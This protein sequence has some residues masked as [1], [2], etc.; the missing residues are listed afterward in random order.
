MR[1]T[2]HIKLAWSK[3]FG[4][5]EVLRALALG[6]QRRGLGRKFAADHAYE[7]EI[8]QDYADIGPE[9]DE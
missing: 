5:P 6:A 1:A 8:A 9:P 4:D 3:A 7:D 2:P